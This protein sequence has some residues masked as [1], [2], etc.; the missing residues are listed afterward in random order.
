MV[1]CTKVK[2]DK[3][4]RLPKFRLVIRACR[5]P[6]GTFTY[7]IARND[8]PSAS[9][10]GPVVFHSLDEAAEAGRLAIERLDRSVHR[11]PTSPDE[12]LLA[13]AGLGAA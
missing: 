8:W 3:E 6:A 10:M 7:V 1:H 9:T 11:N 5:Y 4:T 2:A 13:V 12:T